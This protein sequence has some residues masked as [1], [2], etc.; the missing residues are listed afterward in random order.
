MR[1]NFPSFRL[2][3]WN[4]LPMIRDREACDRLAA[5]MQLAGIP[6]LSGAAPAA[7]AAGPP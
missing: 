2:R 6:D 5:L 4:L 3:G 7:P 1:S